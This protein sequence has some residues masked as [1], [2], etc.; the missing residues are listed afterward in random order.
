MLMAICRISCFWCM[1]KFNR[2][3]KGTMNR[4]STGLSLACDKMG[5]NRYHL[6]HLRHM[7]TIGIS[8]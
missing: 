5:E 6:S 8:E 1:L 4:K 3:N 7:A 2:V